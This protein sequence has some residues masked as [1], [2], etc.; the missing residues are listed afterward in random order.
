MKRCAVEPAWGTRT[1]ATRLRSPSP[2][3]HFAAASAG[4][5]MPCARK[6][7][8]YSGWTTTRLPWNGTVGLLQDRVVVAREEPGEGER[9][10]QLQPRGLRHV[11]QLAGRHRDLGPLLVP[12][13]ADAAEDVLER[14]R[15]EERHHDVVPADPSQL[16]DEAVALRGLGNV[17]REARRED[18]VER[19]GLVRDVERGRLD[20]VGGPLRE[21]LS[22]QLQHFARHVGLDPPLPEG[23]DRAEQAPRARREVENGVVRSDDAEDPLEEFALALVGEALDRLLLVLDV[24]ARGAG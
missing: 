5:P 2:G 1:S 12:Q 11:A 14:P 23:L 20:E 7:G 24:V 16:A 15:V 21:V 6:V 4:D 22:R 13:P 9:A 10:D 19:A 3:A 18:A 17:V 8:S